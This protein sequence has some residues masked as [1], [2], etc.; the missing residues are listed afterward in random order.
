MI[1]GLSCSSLHV[2]DGQTALFIASR[3]GHGQIVELLLRREANVNHQTKVRR[4]LLLCMC[5]CAPPLLG[6]I[7]YSPFMW[8]DFQDYMH[9]HL[10]PPYMYR[11]AE[12]HCL[13]QAVKVMAKLWSFCSGEKLM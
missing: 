12:Q 11:M 8:M 13:L 1:S 7:L 4:L 3:K 10:A 2:Q 5:V 6:C 9:N